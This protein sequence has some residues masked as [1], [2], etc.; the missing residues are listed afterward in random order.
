MF[1]QTILAITF[2]VGATQAID[3]LQESKADIEKSGN[4]SLA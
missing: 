2:I 3:L 1:K 4:T